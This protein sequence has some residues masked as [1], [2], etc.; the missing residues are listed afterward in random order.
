M[1]QLPKKL[2]PK[3]DFVSIA[4]EQS[5]GDQMFKDDEESIGEAMS[6]L[7][8]K[9]IKHR[10]KITEEKVHKIFKAVLRWRHFLS[11]SEYRK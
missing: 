8:F 7:N 4:V 11:I 6:T 5:P 10:G 9:L 3:R 2:D 1:C